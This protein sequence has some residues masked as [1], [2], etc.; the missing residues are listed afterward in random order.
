MQF[1]IKKIIKSISKDVEQTNTD[2][3]QY[4]FL[5]KTLRNLGVEGNF[6]NLKKGILENLEINIILYGERLK[7]P[8]YQIIRMIKIIMVHPSNRT[9]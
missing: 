3:I 5:I 4:P 2:K 7:Q 9:F 6:F 8:K 1:A